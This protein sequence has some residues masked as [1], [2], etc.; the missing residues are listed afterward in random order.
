MGLL[1]L[2]VAKYF[3]LEKYGI[4]HIEGDNIRNQWLL[5]VQD[6]LANGQ[7]LVDT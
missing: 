5:E 7:K 6:Y 2:F 4:G 3:P 1:Y